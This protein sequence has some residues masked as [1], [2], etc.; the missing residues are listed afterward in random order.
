M[1]VWYCTKCDQFA[2]L[3]ENA[4]HPCRKHKDKVVGIDAET[5]KGFVKRFIWEIKKTGRDIQAS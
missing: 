3:F 5:Y 4:D 1:V 2:M